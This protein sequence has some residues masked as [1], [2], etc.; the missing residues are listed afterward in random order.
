MITYLAGALLLAV[1]PTNSQSGAILTFLFPML[2]FIVV[3][4]VLWGLFGRFRPARMDRFQT[5]I[6]A[7]PGSLTASR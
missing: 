2:L 4:L 1:T 6:A 7:G 5:A 3:A